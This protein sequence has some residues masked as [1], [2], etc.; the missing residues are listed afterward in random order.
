M[1]GGKGMDLFKWPL[2]LQVAGNRLHRFH[3]YPISPDRKI[4]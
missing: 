4:P 3:E 2:P 1:T